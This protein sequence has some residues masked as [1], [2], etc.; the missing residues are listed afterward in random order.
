MPRTIAVS[1][2]SLGAVALLAQPASAQPRISNGQIASRQAGANFG[3]TFKSVVGAQVDAGWIGYA[4]PVVAGERNM[5]CSNS[6]GTWVSG[7]VIMSDGACCT[8]CRLE[9]SS[10]RSG[11]STQAP[12]A[13]A[14]RSRQARSLFAHRRPLP[15]RQPHGRT[16]PCVL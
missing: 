8:S 14:G 7:S 13:S 6:G 1:L 5:C 4:V 16:D 11:G 9:P 15:R 3:E 10:Q 2:L 12:S